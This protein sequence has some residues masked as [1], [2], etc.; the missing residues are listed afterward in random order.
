MHSR[1]RSRVPLGRGPTLISFSTHAQRLRSC[2]ADCNLVAAS[3]LRRT[4][5]AAV[6]MCTPYWSPGTYAIRPICVNMRKV[7]GSPEDAYFRA[8]LEHR[9]ANVCTGL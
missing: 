7:E 4:A 6:G 5:F 2:S 3:M 8:W 1:R 9:D